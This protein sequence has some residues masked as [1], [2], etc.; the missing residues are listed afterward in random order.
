M[1][2]IRLGED[3]LLAR[4]KLGM[5]QGQEILAPG[6][7]RI[8]RVGYIPDRRRYEQARFQQLASFVLIQAQVPGQVKHKRLAFRQKTALFPPANRIAMQTHDVS[9]LFLGKLLAFTKVFQ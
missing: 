1:Q 8:A 9:K 3:K 6:K 2:G 4:T 5:K 7:E